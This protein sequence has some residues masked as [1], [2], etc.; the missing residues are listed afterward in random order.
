[1]VLGV[2]NDKN[3]HFTM[4]FRGQKIQLILGI[5]LQNN[6]IFKSV[7]IPKIPKFTKISRHN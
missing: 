5:F 1:M 2:E 4:I 7:T 3:I 6:Y